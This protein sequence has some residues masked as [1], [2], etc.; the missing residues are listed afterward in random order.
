MFRS[1]TAASEGCDRDK[2]RVRYLTQGQT[3]NHDVGGIRVGR[4]R[5]AQSRKAVRTRCMVSASRDIPWPAWE[6]I[7]PREGGRARW[8]AGRPPDLG[9]QLRPLRVPPGQVRVRERIMSMK[10][11]TK[12]DVQGCVCV[13][14]SVTFNF[15]IS[16]IFFIYSASYECPCCLLHHLYIVFC[17][18]LSS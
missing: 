9:P 6:S 4:R 7:S 10:V 17:R 18:Y 15:I 11:L 16:S 8:R 5:G 3:R 2:G 1:T 12:I 13:S 14:V